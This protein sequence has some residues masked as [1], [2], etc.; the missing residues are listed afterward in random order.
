MFGECHAHVIMDG[1]NYKNAVA[2]HAETVQDSVIHQC[3]RD[4]KAAEVT[5]VRDGGDAKGVS[6]RALELA[7]E[8]GIDYRTPIF[9]IHKKGHYG[10]I[11]G[12]AFSDWA[13]YRQLIDQVRKS[14]GS[15]IKIMISGLVDFGAYGVLSEP[16]L[17]GEEIR[18]MIETAHDA[19][20]SVMAHGNGV[21]T[22]SAAIAAGVDTIEHG[23]YLNDEV[24]C[25]LA[26]SNTIWI[27]TMAP[28]GNLLGCGRFPDEEV[29]KILNRQIENVR[30]AVSLGAVVGLGSDAGAYLVPHGKG[31]FDEYE[32]M[33][34]AVPDEKILRTMLR[35]AEDR[36]KRLF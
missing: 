18:I 6:K 16:G 28:T 12:R 22:V 10:G 9:A 35:N 2:L 11:V 27:P 32:Y 36:I 34:Q 15:F 25:Q 13:E 30:K 17:T 31:L 26:G 4:W 7:P 14:G 8:Y 33:K 24:L 19:G 29:E 1:V 20:F 21:D 3:F 23:N 5:F